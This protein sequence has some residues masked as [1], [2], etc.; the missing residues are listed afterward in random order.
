MSVAVK[1]GTTPEIKLLL[2][3]LRVIVTL[4]E[5]VPS[6]VTGPAPAVIVELALEAAPLVNETLEVAAP[7][8]PAGV[9]IAKVLTSATLEAKVQVEIPVVASLLEQVVIVLPDPVSVALKVGTT[10]G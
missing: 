2:A 3:S 4:N 9:T 8:A 6:A 5:A 1:A 10:L 7:D